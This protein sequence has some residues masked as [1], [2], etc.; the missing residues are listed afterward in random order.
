[1]QFML[2]IFM[3]ILNNV[4]DS[5]STLFALIS[6]IMYNIT[7]ILLGGGHSVL[8]M[9]FPSLITCPSG[10]AQPGLHIRGH[11]GLGFSQVPSQ[12]AHSG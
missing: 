1:M 4:K 7:V 8:S 6:L 5:E 11:G 3:R 12:G 10:Q 9:H 2:V